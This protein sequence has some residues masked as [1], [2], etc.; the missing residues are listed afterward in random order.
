MEELFRI[1]KHLAHT[2]ENRLRF[3]FQIFQKNYFRIFVWTS[4][5]CKMAWHQCPFIWYIYGWVFDLLTERE[6]SCWCF[7]YPFIVQKNRNDSDLILCM[8]VFIWTGVNCVYF[9][10]RLFIAH[11]ISSKCTFIRIVI[12]EK[13]SSRFCSPFSENGNNSHC[14]SIE[15]TFR[16]H[17]EKKKRKRNEEKKLFTNTTF[18]I[19]FDKYKLKLNTPKRN[20]FVVYFTLYEIQLKYRKK[21]SLEHRKWH[22]CLFLFASSG[23]FNN[24]LFFTFSLAPSL[25]IATIYFQSFGR[26]R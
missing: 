6:Y 5:V 10:D 1:L 19:V 26:T 17:R 18:D 8:H 12:I 9:T 20:E 21:L 4:R 22:F 2:N 16:T 15:R 24:S 13:C 3:L 11:N 25:F 23:R 14:H 7:F